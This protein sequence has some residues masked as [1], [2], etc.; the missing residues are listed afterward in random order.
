M[1]HMLPLRS[2]GELI[3][4]FFNIP[5]HIIVKNHSVFDNEYEITYPVRLEPVD[6]VKATLKN[7]EV[8]SKF[9]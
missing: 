8:V 6:Q 3:Q 5:I 1:G 2:H 4:R 7:I 9:R